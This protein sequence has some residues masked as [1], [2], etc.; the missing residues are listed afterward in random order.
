M[1]A[2]LQKSGLPIYQ[3][4]GSKKL[5]LEAP[6]MLKGYGEK[7][8]LQMSELYEDSSHNDKHENVYDVYRGII[9]DQD[10]ELFERYKFQYDITVIHQGQV[11]FECKK[12]SG[13]YHG[14]ESNKKHSYP[15]VYEV[16][17]GTAMFELQKSMNFD[18]KEKN[19]IK[20]DDIILAKVEAGQAIIVPPDY[21]HCSINIGNGDLVFSNLAYKPCEIFY[22]NVR[23]HH[24]LGIYIGKED[25]KLKFKK[26]DHYKN[27]PTVKIAL[28][29]ENESL[30]IKFNQPVYKTFLETPDKY[31]FLGNPDKYVDTIM[32]MF[33]I[34]ESF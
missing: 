13:H 25:D 30:G 9:C 26:N 7:N 11:G 32:K 6:Y 29:V 15:E 21:G 17:S 34:K 19:D 20:V 3:N 23:Y 14:W 16:L 5:L 1:L 22:D 18:V 28:P 4:N 10:R 12:T 8:V 27:L 31:N 2:E 33:D 24:G